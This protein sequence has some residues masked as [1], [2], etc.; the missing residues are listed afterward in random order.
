MTRPPSGVNFTALDRRLS[1]ICL[2]ARRSA[3]SWKSGDLR[4][5]NCSC[6]SCA[7][8]ADDAHGVVEQRSSSSSSRSSR[9]RPASIFDMSRMSLMTS[10]RY[11]PLWWMSRQYSLIF[12]GAERAEH[13]RFHDLG[14]ADDGVERRAQLVAHVGE[15]FRLRLVGFLG[16]GLFLGVFLGEF[17]ECAAASARRSA[18]VAI[19]RFSLSISFSS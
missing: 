17:G 5:V 4:A 9:M 2:S 13:A 7:R 6:L 12:V 15:E 16:A 10:S 19:S 18:T 1:A 3:R 14:E 11:W 8:A